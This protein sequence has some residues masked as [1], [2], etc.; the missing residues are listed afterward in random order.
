MNKCVTK[1]YTFHT[2]NEKVCNFLHIIKN[3][4]TF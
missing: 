2:K 4:D 1:L 3:F